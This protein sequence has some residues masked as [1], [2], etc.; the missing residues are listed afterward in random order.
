MSPC[1][2]SSSQQ[3]PAAAGENRIL[4]LAARLTL[5]SPTPGVWCSI[6][7]STMIQKHHLHHVLTS[8]P[9]FGFVF[10]NEALKSYY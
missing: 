10:K 5:L 2:G 9:W 8:S 7:F 4:G 6:L 1:G 3:P